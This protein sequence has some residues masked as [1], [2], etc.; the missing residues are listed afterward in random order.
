MLTLTVFQNSEQLM[1]HPNFHV[2]PQQPPGAVLGAQPRANPH[3]QGESHRCSQ[4]LCELC[5]LVLTCQIT[6]AGNGLAERGAGSEK[7][8]R[9]V[10]LGGDQQR[11]EPELL[12]H[13]SH[14]SREQAGKY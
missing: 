4:R 1:L 9:R 13:S 8:S 12:K 3:C 14:N 2:G 5:S 6:S 10:H 11:G 7:G